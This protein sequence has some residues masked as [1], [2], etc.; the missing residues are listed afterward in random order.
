M[1]AQIN[2]AALFRQVVQESE[3]FT[4]F[5]IERGGLNALR[6]PRVHVVEPQRRGEGV[7]LGQGL[8]LYCPAQKERQATE[9]I[10]G[11]PLL[12]LRQPGALTV[13]QVR[14]NVGG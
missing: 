2:R 4:Q 12:D 9:G 13:A 8:L 14:A 7:R 5:R 3:D 10:A 6:Q 11:C 1:R